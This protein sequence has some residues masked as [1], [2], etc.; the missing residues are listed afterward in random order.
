MIIR[1]VPSP[2]ILAGSSSEPRFWYWF[3]ASGRRYI[4][5]IY[6]A[7]QCPP[8]PGAVFIAVKRT[9]TLRTA[10]AVGRFSVFWELGAVRETG[11]GVDEF[12]VHLLARD[13]EDAEA[14]ADDLERALRGAP[15][16]PTEREPG[17]PQVFQATGRGCQARADVPPC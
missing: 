15:P 4:H 7:G 2:T 17:L 6:P 14:I 9:G 8:L 11:P 5:S 3:G 12:H 1:G 16:R 13:D 10:I